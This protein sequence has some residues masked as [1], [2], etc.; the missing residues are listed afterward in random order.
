M[1]ERL[2]LS[3]LALAAFCPRKL[4]YA[5]QDDRS[6]PPEHAAALELSRQYETLLADPDSTPAADLAVPRGTFYERLRALRSS[7]PRWADL[8]DP[9]RTDVLLTGK[10]VRG[11]VAKVLADSLAPTIVS[12]GSPPPEGVWQPQTVKAVGAAKALAWTAS[13][14][15]ETAYVEYP[16]HGIVR[17]V[18][19]TT[20]RKAT[21]RRTLRAVRSMDGPPPRIG[22]DAKCETCR[23]AG[24]CGTQT[25]SLASLLP[26]G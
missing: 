3:D 12:A 10:D 19:L 7:H 24:E 13:T 25:R 23:F 17:S 15:V 6:P 18:P 11:R 14:E 20:R 8:V 4:Y 1:S 22:D 2:A 26:G 21:Y 5:R 9:D 16:R